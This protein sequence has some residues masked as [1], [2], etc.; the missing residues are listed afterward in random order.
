MA[1]AGI[2][3]NPFFSIVIPVCNVAPYLRECLD[4]VLGQTFAGWEAI[5]VDDGSSDGSGAILD[6]YAAK[7]ARIKVLHTE[8]RGVSAAR[9]SA[10]DTASGEYVTFLDGDDA[11]EHFWLESFLGLIKE[12]GAEL[13]RLRVRYWNGGAYK[14]GQAVDRPHRVCFVGDEV[15]DWGCSTYAREG[16]SW[17]NAVKRSCLNGAVRVRFP[18]GMRFMEDNIFMMRALPYVHTACQGEVAGYL[19]RQRATS[20]CMGKNSTRVITRLFDETAQ[21][22]ASMSA[23]NRKY[24]SGMLGRSILY[25]CGHRDRDETGGDAIVRARVKKAMKDS[26]FHISDMPMKWRFGIWAMLSLHTL[27]VMDFL[28]YLAGL[29]KRRTS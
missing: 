27:L 12:T 10:I 3:M 9:N 26:M 14:N 29:R 11:Y 4:S 25:W 8:N 16:W 20:V 21:L 6:E 17:L 2:A 1:K 28:L 22:F 13:V 18:A 15:V 24:L 7:D 5:C 23:K 19:Y